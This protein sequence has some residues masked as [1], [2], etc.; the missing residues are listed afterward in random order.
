[1]VA[2][3]QDKMCEFS[4]ANLMLNKEKQDIVAEQTALINY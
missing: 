1:M 3:K 2:I 4:T